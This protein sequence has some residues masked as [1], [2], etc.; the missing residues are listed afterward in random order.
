MNTKAKC[1]H[2]WII[3][4]PDGPESKGQ[5]KNC[6]A[7]GVFQNY[8]SITKHNSAHTGWPTKKANRKEAGADQ[9]VSNLPQPNF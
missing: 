6:G 5:C 9:P 3:E 7:V 4:F 8:A 1:I 2:Y